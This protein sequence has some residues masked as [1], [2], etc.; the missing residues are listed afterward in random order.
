VVR[1]AFAE[2][3]NVTCVEG[4]DVVPDESDAGTGGKQG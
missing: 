1:Q 4:G 2:Q 3:D